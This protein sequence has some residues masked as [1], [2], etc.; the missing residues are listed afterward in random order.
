MSL[1][2]LFAAAAVAGGITTSASSPPAP[3]CDTLPTLRKGVVT[4]TCSA[5]DPKDKQKTIS[6]TVA[7]PAICVGGGCGLVMDIHG[8]TMTAAQQEKSDHFQVLGNAAGY[9]VIQPTAPEDSNGKHD[10]KPLV[11]HPQLL[12]FFRYAAEA[13]KADRR[14]VHVMGYSQG[15]FASWNLLCQAPEL[16]CS[17][18]PL[19]A[20]A[21]DQWGAGYGTGVCF[22]PPAKGPSTPRSILFTNG[23]TDTLSHI[24]NARKQVA[25]VQKAWGLA[26]GTAHNTSGFKYTSRSWQQPKR[27][28]TYLEH[29]YNITNQFAEQIKGHCFP[30]TAADGCQMS[31]SHYVFRC[32]GA[33]TWARRVLAFFQDNPCR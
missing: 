27:N 29:D 18:A 14:R 9:V 2:W 6:Y 26:D 13:L 8:F 30:T 1:A 16:I 32:C 19:E 3:S 24:D 17:A 4:Y 5:A 31:D 23:I 22:T 21:L 20:S 25:N 28:F 10:W 15:G 7:T 33:F 12:I 11:H